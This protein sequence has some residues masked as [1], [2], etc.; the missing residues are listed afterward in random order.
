MMADETV[1]D[2]VLRRSGPRTSKAQ[3]SLSLEFDTVLQM[4]VRAHGSPLIYTVKLVFFKICKSYW[5]N[6]YGLTYIFFLILLTIGIKKTCTLLERIKTKI[7][8]PRS[9]ST[10]K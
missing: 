2:S 10:L 5:H 1:P 7:F 3:S 9:L 8:G 6:L 4:I